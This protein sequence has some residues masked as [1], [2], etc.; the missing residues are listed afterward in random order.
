MNRRRFV[1]VLVVGL[2]GLGAYIS[3][4]AAASKQDPGPA[5]NVEQ[6]F[7]FQLKPVGPDNLPPPGDNW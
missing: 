6:H 1:S 7:Q 3:F 5:P 2:A 4:A